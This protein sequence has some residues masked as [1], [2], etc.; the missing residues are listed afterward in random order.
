MTSESVRKAVVATV[1]SM[2]GCSTEVNVEVP[3]ARET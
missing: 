2:A 1:R 3:G